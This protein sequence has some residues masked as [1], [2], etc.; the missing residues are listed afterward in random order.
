MK[1]LF[2]T[3]FVVGFIGFGLAYAEGGLSP[4]LGFVVGFL[5][6]YVVTLCYLL[7]QREMPLQALPLAS[8]ESTKSGEAAERHYLNQYRVRL[9]TELEQ[10]LSSPQ[11]SPITLEEARRMMGLLEIEINVLR[12]IFDQAE[13][14][15]KKEEQSSHRHRS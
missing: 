9:M 1:R 3:A 5:G 12:R 10:T 2:P 8:A 7:L 11:L 14:R 13:L 15:M 4:L 6:Y